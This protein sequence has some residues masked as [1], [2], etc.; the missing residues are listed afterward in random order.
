MDRCPYCHKPP[1][2][3]KNEDGTWNWKN[4]FHI[5]WIMIIVIVMFLFSAWA[6]K[7]DTAECRKL[8]SDP[9]K[10]IDNLDCQKERGLIYETNKFPALVFNQTVS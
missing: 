5:D 3:I 10:Y 1:Y 9:C 8:I 7:H 4:L 6:Y 2:P